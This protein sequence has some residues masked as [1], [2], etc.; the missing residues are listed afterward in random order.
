MSKHYDV[1]IVGWWSN[2][3]YGGT[4]TYFALNQ[5]L[6]SMGKSVLMIQRSHPQKL[7]PTFDTVPGRF[8]KKHYDI[9]ERYTYEEM[10]QLNNICDAFVAGSDQLWNPHLMPWSGPEFFL[11]FAAENK[12][13]VAYATSFGNISNCGAEFISKYGPLLKRLDAISVREDFAVDIC[14]SDFGLESCQICDPVFLC[15]VDK[16][17]K[18]ADASKKK[19]PK[20]YVL[21][22][23][24]DPNSDKTN[25]CAHVREKLGIADYVNFTDL[26]KVEEKVQDFGGEFVYANA[27]IEDFVKA[28]R[29]AEFVITDSFHGTCFA[30][31]F[32]KPFISFANMQRGEKRFISL[33]KWLKQ[34]DRLVFDYNEVYTRDDLLAPVDYTETNK[35]IEEGRKEGFKWLNDALSLEKP[36]TENG[37]Q[38]AIRLSEAPQKK[39]DMPKPNPNVHDD[40]KRCRMLASL[41][42]DYNVRHIVLSSGTRHVELVR[43]FEANDCFITH[44]V[45]DERSAGFYALG[46]ATKLREPVAVCCTSGTASSNYLTSVSEAFYQKVPLIFITG[47]RYPHLLNQ[48]EDQMV[49][50][51]NMYGDV[52]LKSVSLPTK[53]GPVYEAVARRMICEAI[54]EATHRTPGP[55][56][57]NFPIHFFN[58]NKQAESEYILDSIHYPKITRHM[59][60][61]DRSNWKEPVSVLSSEAKILVIYGQGHKLGSVG[62]QDLENFAKKTNCVILS[63]HNTNARCSKTVYPYNFL[64][65][66]AKF[67]PETVA[68]LNPDIV[69]TVNGTFVHSIGVLLAKCKN[70]RHWEIS[71]SGTVADP[72]KKITKVFECNDTQFF[73]RINAM[74]EK[75]SNSDNYYKAW[76]SVEILDDPIPDSYTQKYAIG[77]MMKTIPAN[78]MLHIANSRATYMANSYQLN[79]TVEVFGNRGTKGID[80][81][82]STFMGQAAVN[83]GLSFLMIGDLSFF[84]DMNGIWN[85]KLNGNIRIAMFNN[86][87][88][89]LLKFHDADAITHSHTAVAEGWAKSLGFTYLSARTMEEYEANLSR[90]TSVI[91]DKPMFFEIFAD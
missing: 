75:E 2:L 15:D 86:S 33:L 58:R 47:D 52:C 69:I 44:P 8:S 5:A 36:V 13:K 90:F 34:T 25:V 12:T 80:G 57:I 43:L 46:L 16:Y 6:E 53:E 29:D 45:L 21:N 35:I 72:F 88:A 23:L 66:P 74:I 10:V 4:M 42:R 70:Y 78:S 55:V 19:Y 40:I 63:D 83:N 65:N 1:G 56:Q 24:L 82:V 91:E 38:T 11:S 27:E 32:N 31:I 17:K 89:G 77:R 81:S 54:L 14:K 87:G 67:T 20:K 9:S 84:Y 41:L 30:I 49:P 68:K 71:A 39:K 22:F 48:R 50:Q 62:L 28:Y 59:F 64:K 51:V 3:N 73:K 85:K 60:L 61:P 79:P 18:L 76:K 7:K 37:M 26:Q